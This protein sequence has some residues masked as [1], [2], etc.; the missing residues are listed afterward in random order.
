MQLQTKSLVGLLQQAI[1]EQL[2]YLP[3]KQI[4]IVLELPVP[5]VLVKTDAGRFLQ[6]MSNLL[7]NAKKFSPAN[8]EIKIETE[9][10]A[11]FAK[12]SIADQGPGIADS[13]IP[14]LFSQFRQQ[15]DSISREYGG[16]G[17]GLSICKQLTELMGGDIGY[18]K[19]EDGGATFW[20]TTV[21]AVFKNEG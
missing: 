4:Q 2:Y 6:I 3:E 11:G 5:D 13:F 20:F 14:L 9:I 1:D 8:S 7:S 18:Q 21:L 15:D 19:S 17:L 10:L 12:V 16:T